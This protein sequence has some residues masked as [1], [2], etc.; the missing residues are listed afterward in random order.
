MD[1]MASVSKFRS[2]M[3]KANDSSKPMIR[4]KMISKCFHKTK[5]AGIFSHSVESSNQGDGQSKTNSTS[6]VLDGQ[7]ISKCL[8]KGGES[9]N[10]ING[11]TQNEAKSKELDG[12]QI[13][14]FLQRAKRVGMFSQL[15]GQTDES[16]DHVKDSLATIQLD[17]VDISD[18]DALVPTQ[19][20]KGSAIPEWKR[21]V[22]VRKLHARLEEEE[23]KK[24][25]SRE[26]SYMP[27]GGWRYS[28]AHNAVLGPYGEL[29]TEEDLLYLETQI[30]GLQMRCKHKEYGSELKRLAEEL[31]NILPAPIINITVNTQFLDQDPGQDVQA[32]LPVW[33]N[34]ISGAVNSF[35]QTLTNVNKK[36]D[37]FGNQVYSLEATEIQPH[38]AVHRQLGKCASYGTVEREILEFGVSVRNLRSNFE[39]QDLPGQTNS[40]SHQPQVFHE[41]YRSVDDFLIQ[42]IPYSDNDHNDHASGEENTSDSGI[43]SEDNSCMNDSPVPQGLPTIMRKE[44]IVVL[45]LSHWK[46]SAYSISEKFK[47]KQTQDSLSHQEASE[48][49]LGPTGMGRELPPPNKPLMASN[50]LVHLLTQRGVIQKLIENWK[51]LIP[52]VPSQQIQKLNRQKVT[53]SPEQFLPL[54]NGRQL[55]YNSLTLD[56]FMLG[57]FHILELDLPKKERQMRHLLCFEVFDHLG[58]HG[59]EV[60]RAFHKAVTEEINTGNREWSDGF[61]DIRKLFFGQ[62]KRLVSMEM[63]NR[64]RVQSTKLE[65]AEPIV[66]EANSKSIEGLK[67]DEICSYIDRSFAFWKEKEAE[68]FDFEE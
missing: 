35:S 47:A 10:H 63:S 30:E 8:Q 37:C 56:L 26:G 20:G 66:G 41:S 54:M 2:K 4:D 65:R 22:M 21:Q 16:P 57:Y 12:L 6:L 34:R 7:K 1:T 13:S 53:Y 49:S 36:P 58:T 59:W 51:G 25:K 52:S 67:N 61:E 23:E 17:D 43:S 19:D 24:R 33:C 15:K 31:Q 50:K 60:V 28:Q 18:L 46:K 68:L 29:M 62:E 64:L 32:S 38:V 48:S 40:T 42:K 45:F 5:V 9:T 39:K 55:D 3:G 27:M 14:T 44:R 11:Q